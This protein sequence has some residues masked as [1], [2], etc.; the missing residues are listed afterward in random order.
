[1]GVLTEG[2]D[3]PSTGAIFLARPT[4]SRTLFTQ[5]V[6]RGLRPYPGKHDCLLVDMTVVDTRALETGTL[7]GRMVKCR[8]CDTEYYA[9][10]KACPA[11]GAEHPIHKHISEDGLFMHNLPTQVGDGLIINYDALFEQAF[12]AWYHGD[13]GFM[14]CTLTFEDGALIIIPPLEDNYYRLA[15]VPKDYEKPVTFLQRNEDLAALMLDAERIVKDAGGRAADKDAP[16]RRDPASPA[17]YGVLSKLDV[18]APGGLSKGA[19]SQLITHAI[20]VK[21][22]ISAT[23][24]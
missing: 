5:I 24:R 16:W 10:L 21:R 22:L 13:D 7:L 8:E 14:S 12:A 3:A 23:T 19:A 18:K 9:G 15:R 4:R 6:G 2:F 20:A 11:C 17:Q 1:M